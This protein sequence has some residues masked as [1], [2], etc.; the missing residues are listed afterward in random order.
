MLIGQFDLAILL[1]LGS[2]A[3]ATAAY[4]SS[5]IA[6]AETA[7]FSALLGHSL[8]VPDDYTEEEADDN[9]VE[10][11]DGDGC[12]EAERF[13]GFKTAESTKEE[14]QSIRQRGYGNSRACVG[15]SMMDSVISGLLQVSLVNS[16]AH[17][18]HVVDANAD[19]QEWHKLMHTCCLAA[20]EV[21][22]TETRG[23]G[24]HNTYETY[25]SNDATAVHGAEVAQC[26][27]S[28][29]TDEQDSARDQ[30]EIIVDVLHDSD[31]EALN[32]EHVH[33]QF[34]CCLG[35][36]IDL[37]NKS[38]FEAEVCLF[39]NVLIACV[40]NNVCVSY[41]FCTLQ[42]VFTNVFHIFEVLF[43]N[44][45]NVRRGRFANHQ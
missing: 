26:E 3:E 1:L 35:V 24:E 18:K 2:L 20:T 36:C 17:D 14:S 43:C 27:E 22:Q 38:V 28:V 33:S 8:C 31:Q 39:I 23:V 30:R 45:L 40:P 9:K 16:V 10:H 21:H 4:D 44:L 34:R 37:F 42:L 5:F 32:C 41:S 6:H 13:K 15:K 12:E 25:Q 29:D 19:Q 7:A 11:D